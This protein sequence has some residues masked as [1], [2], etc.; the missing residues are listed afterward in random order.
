LA[1]D[2]DVFVLRNIAFGGRSS[3]Y[4]NAGKLCMVK[5]WGLTAKDLWYYLLIAGANVWSWGREV[6]IP[7]EGLCDGGN[8][9]ILKL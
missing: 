2:L 3:R 1:E 6:I 9:F 5:T 7:T 4:T 8:E